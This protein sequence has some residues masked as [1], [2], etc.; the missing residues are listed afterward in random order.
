[1]HEKVVRQKGGQAS[2]EMFPM[3]AGEKA[4]ILCKQLWGGQRLVPIMQKRGRR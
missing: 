4:D 2:P 1:M 3:Q